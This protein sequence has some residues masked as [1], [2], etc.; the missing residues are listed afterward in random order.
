MTGSAWVP[1]RPPS[2]PWVAKLD[3]AE[4]ADAAV[5]AHRQAGRRSAALT[6]QKVA[7]RLAAECEGAGTPGLPEPVLRQA[8]TR[9]EAEIAALAVQGLSDRAIADRL[10]T[11]VRT[12]ESHLRR[13]SAKLGIAGRQ[14]VAA[15]C[16]SKGE[17]H[18]PPLRTAKS[19]SGTMSR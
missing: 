3:A 12:A 9:R 7:S 1:P 16:R 5:D 13:V 19:G 17:P 14:H 10:V 2:S 4:A 18:R 8:L 15:R 6:S 11:S